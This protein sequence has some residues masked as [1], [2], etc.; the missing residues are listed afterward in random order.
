MSDESRKRAGLPDK[1]GN[2]SFFV[3]RRGLSIQRGFIRININLVMRSGES[4]CLETLGDFIGE[5]EFL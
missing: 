1:K 4:I 3:L 5:P 2:G